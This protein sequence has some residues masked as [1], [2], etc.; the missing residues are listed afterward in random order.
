MRKAIEPLGL[1][2]IPMVAAYAPSKSAVRNHTKR[3]LSI[4][5][6]D[7]AHIRRYRKDAGAL[8]WI[9]REYCS[10]PALLSE[11]SHGSYAAT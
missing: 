6:S 9:D 3:A 11:H 5:P 8:P 10:L 1:G 7:F 2:W 4:V